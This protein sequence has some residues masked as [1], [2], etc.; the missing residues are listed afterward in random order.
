MPEFAATR[1]I[2]VGDARITFLADGGGIV[3]PLAL[4]PASTAAGWQTHANLLDQEGRFIT[5]IG[6]FLI[7]RGAHVIAVDLGIGPHTI[8]FPG[9]GPFSGGG[10]LDSLAQTGVAPG[11]VTDVIFTHLHL[12]HCGWVTQPANGGRRLTYP[13]ARYWVTQT[14]WDFWYGGDNPAGPHPLFV[15]QP[16]KELVQFIRGGDEIAPGVTA[17]ATPGH[18]PGHI[19]LRI[20]AGEQRVFLT[21]DVLHGAMQLRERDWSVAFDVDAALARQS[22]EQL[23]AELTRPNTIV[24]VNHFSDAVFGRISQEGENYR[25]TPLGA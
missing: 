2:G 6:G 20:D 1:S 18:T 25:W 3:Q 5:S 4:Y 11:T 23:Y 22:R 9:F 10:Y 16:L 15:Q 7:E 13:N 8:D 17:V 24:A 12:D 21:G 14:E 19:S